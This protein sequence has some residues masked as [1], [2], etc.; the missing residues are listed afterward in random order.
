MLGGAI[1]NRT[2][3]LSRAVGAVKSLTTEA[4]TASTETMERATADAVSADAWTRVLRRRKEATAA[5]S[6]NSYAEQC[7]G[8]TTSKA[9][10]TRNAAAAR[11]IITPSNAATANAAAAGQLI[12]SSNACEAKAIAANLSAGHSKPKHPTALG[13]K[14]TPALASS[15]HAT[16]D[17]DAACR[18]T[19]TGD[20]NTA[21]VGQLARDGTEATSKS[22]ADACAEGHANAWTL[23]TPGR[24]KAEKGN[25]S[26]RK[27]DK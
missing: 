9:D 26:S 19:G 21:V 24:K 11:N 27:Y 20:S 16:A 15:P 4:R 5:N 6:T 17:A 18:S 3:D 2:G 1:P 14:E 25:S 10:G 8:E 22:V 13:Y 12:K 7:K 23:V